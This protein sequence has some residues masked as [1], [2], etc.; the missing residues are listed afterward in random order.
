MTEKILSRVLHALMARR[1]FFANRLTCV[2]ICVMVLVMLVPVGSSLAENLVPGGSDASSIVAHTI[3]DII[4]YARWP[5]EPDV[6][7]ICITGQ[8]AY[9]NDML[10]QTGAVAGHAVHFRNIELNSDMLLSTCTVVYIGS[11]RDETRKAILTYAKRYTVLT[12]DEEGSNCTSGAMFCLCIVDGR[13]SLQINLD[14]ISRSG[15]RINPN[16]LL[17]ARRKSAQP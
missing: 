16:V 17:L 5:A 15:I 6:Y 9:L 1:R 11:V 8:T 12:I 7:Q 10:V 3:L 14:A 4:S 13:V 2:D